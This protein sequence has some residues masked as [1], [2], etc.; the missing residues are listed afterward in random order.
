MGAE[1]ASELLVRF[2]STV[3]GASTGSNRIDNVSISGDLI[4]AP[5]AIALLAVAGLTGGTR[6]RR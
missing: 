4:P 3:G 6:R 1:N 5:G 2:R